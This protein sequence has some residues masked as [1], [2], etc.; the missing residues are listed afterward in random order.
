MSFNVFS[1]FLA[2]FKILLP[3]IKMHLESVDGWRVKRIL[4]TFLDEIPNETPMNAI[5]ELLIQRKI[6]PGKCGPSD[7]AYLAFCSRSP[8]SMSLSQKDGELFVLPRQQLSY[9]IRVPDMPCFEETAV[10][11][12][13]TFQRAPNVEK[14]VSSKP[15]I[16]YSGCSF[17]V[18]S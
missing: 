11:I 3:I 10:I 17:D 12:P 13:D 2:I 8:N 15:G 4:V 16:T 1:V 18:L 6:Q 5:N 7:P 9:W 14:V